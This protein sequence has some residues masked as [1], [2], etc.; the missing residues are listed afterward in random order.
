MIEWGIVMSKNYGKPVTSER[1]KVFSIEEIENILKDKIL[2]GMDVKK[3]DKSNEDKFTMLEGEEI[4]TFSDR[5]KTFFSKGYVCSCCGLK[6]SYFALEKPVGAKRA[7]LNLYGVNEN[8]EEI[9][10]TKDHITPKSLGGKNEVENY[11]TMCMK[12][13]TEKGNSR[14]G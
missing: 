12:C 3:R 7:H 11:Q 9:L 4:H 8:G 14:I 5:Y 10:F 13:N 1:I 6:A 2:N